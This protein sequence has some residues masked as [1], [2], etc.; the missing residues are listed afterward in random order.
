MTRRWE[1]Y[2]REILET[3]VR[4]NYSMAGVLRSLGLKLAGGSHTH[5]SRR[6]KALGIDTSHFL[7]QGSNRGPD[8]RGPKPLTCEQV[9]VLRKSGN[10]Q[11][12]R[13]L[14]KALLE[15]GRTYRCEGEGCPLI[16][17][18]LGKP[19]VLHVNHKNGDWLDDRAENL[20]F[21]CPNCHSQTS[22]YCRGMRP[23]QRTSQAEWYREYRK[24]RKPCK[25][26]VTELADVCGLGPQV[27]T[28]VR[29][30]VPPGPID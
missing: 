24:R 12:A 22:T 18:W 9:F 14:R 4:Q 17:E 23:E 2:T 7:G 15:S 21:L 19:L 8:H 10:R 20:E 27:L 6:I 29:V 3:A 28:D 26:P 11:K 5:I 13:I 30:R 25:G 1:K 16:D